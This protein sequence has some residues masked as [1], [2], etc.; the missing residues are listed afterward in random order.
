VSKGG[1]QI[2][3]Q[4]LQTQGMMSRDR[5]APYQTLE[6]CLIAVERRVSLH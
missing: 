4:V 6:I 5:F 2:H 1:L 3:Q